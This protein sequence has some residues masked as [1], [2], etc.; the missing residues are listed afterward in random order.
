[1]SIP[2]LPSCYFFAMRHDYGSLIAYRPAD[3]KSV[4]IDK[5]VSYEN[6]CSD[7][8]HIQVADSLIAF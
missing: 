2:I 8:Y 7:K 4:E 6:S 3:G 1:M 5:F